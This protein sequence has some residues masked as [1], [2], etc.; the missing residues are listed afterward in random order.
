MECEIISYTS[1]LIFCKCNGNIRH[2]SSERIIASFI[3][4]QQ[5]TIVRVEDD[6]DVQNEED[7]I[8]L[9][10]HIVYVPAVFSKEKTDPEVGLMFG[11][12]YCSC[13]CV[14]LCFI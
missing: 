14:C 13:S 7:S 9:K 12:F 5:K 6:V 3:I 2:V 10:S 1:C 8:D 4:L 11:C